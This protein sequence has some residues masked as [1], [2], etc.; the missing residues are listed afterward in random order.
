M[1]VS[2]RRH[3]ETGQQHSRRT[4][5]YYYT[6][7]VSAVVI[8]GLKGTASRCIVLLTRTVTYIEDT[9][10]FT[11]GALR[12]ASIILNSVVFWSKSGC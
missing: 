9:T 4:S 10:S 5:I 1:R 3:R 8:G 2:H 12:M 7:K 11:V 6:Y